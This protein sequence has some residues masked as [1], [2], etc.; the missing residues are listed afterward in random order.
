MWPN[1]AGALG[2]GANMAIYQQKDRTRIL[3]WKLISDVL[4]ALHYFLL[5]AY[6]GCAVAVIGM[7][8]EGIF[9]NKD[10]KWAKHVFWLYFF[11]GVSLASAILTWKSAAS[12]LPATASMLSVISFWQNKPNFTRFAAFPISICMLSYDIFSGSY[13]GI[14]NEIFTLLSATL[15]LV[16]FL[17][18]GDKRSS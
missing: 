9:I 8:R 16:R 17:R 14:C 11:L 18:H 1:I 12:L 6:S 4:W 13:M 5:G 15:G 2:I 10:K 7:A 3:I